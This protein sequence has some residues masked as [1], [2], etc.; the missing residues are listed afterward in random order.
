M[1]MTK[2]QIQTALITLLEDMTQDWDLDVEEIT[3]QTYLAKDLNFSSVDII[4]LVV[5]TE[6]LFKQKLGFDSLLMKDGRYVDDL[7]IA[8]WVNFIESKLNGGTP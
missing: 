6:E 5:S 2:A 4:Q 8:Q 1:A 3:P 7:S